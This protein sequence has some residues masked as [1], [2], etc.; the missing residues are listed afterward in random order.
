M[1]VKR[2]IST[3]PRLL[4]GVFFRGAGAPIR[5]LL[6]PESRGVPEVVCRTDSWSIVPKICDRTWAVSWAIALDCSTCLK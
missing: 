4:V 2:L 6:V 3:R 5:E 1:P